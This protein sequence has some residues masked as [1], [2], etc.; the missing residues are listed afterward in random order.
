ME[1][2]PQQAPSKDLDG[3]MTLGRIGRMFLFFMT[4]GF[5]YPNVMIEGL[6]PTAIQAAT[7]GKL[8]DKK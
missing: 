2:K 1:D 5:A 6:D 4:A 8:Y 7:M 3:K